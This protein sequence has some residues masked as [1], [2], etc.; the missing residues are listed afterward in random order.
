[1]ADATARG[2]HGP[3]V[4]GFTSKRSAHDIEAV[5]NYVRSSFIEIS[6][7]RQPAR[8]SGEAK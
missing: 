7:S 8:P 2:S 5:V 6:A 3:G 1:M 4:A